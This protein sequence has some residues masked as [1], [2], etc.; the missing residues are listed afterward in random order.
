MLDTHKTQGTCLRALWR[1]LLFR[2]LFPS[3]QGFLGVLMQPRKLLFW[4][5]ESTDLEPSCLNSSGVRLAEDGV[6]GGRKGTGCL[7]LSISCFGQPLSGAKRYQHLRP[8]REREATIKG[9][10]RQ[11][12]G[13][14]RRVR[15]R[16]QNSGAV[17]AAARSDHVK[18]DTPWNGPK[19]K[20]CLRL[21]RK[22]LFSPPRR[23]AGEH[24]ERRTHVM[25]WCDTHVR[26][27]V[28]WTTN[29]RG[30]EPDCS[31]MTLP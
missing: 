27:P 26:F 16:Q 8:P 23:I 18:H 17:H 10:G 19:W 3:G 4:I 21:R 2:P 6:L 28:H 13:S 12:G 29:R 5:L 14:L 24:L 1:R 7:L 11:V 20:K 22:T 31:T 15:S 30:S 25:C 9:L